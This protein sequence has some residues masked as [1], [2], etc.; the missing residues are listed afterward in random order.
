MRP[1]KQN[2]ERFQN[3][4]KDIFIIKNNPGPFFVFVFLCQATVTAVVPRLHTLPLF[5]KG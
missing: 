1:L 2:Q 3:H 4:N 5:Y